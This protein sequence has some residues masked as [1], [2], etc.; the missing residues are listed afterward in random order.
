[1]KK[2]GLW[3]DHR[4]TVLVSMDGDPAAVR[5]RTIESG[6]ESRPRMG[7]G[8]GPAT[9]Y[10]AQDASYEARRDRRHD[11]QLDQYYDRVIEAVSGANQ[12]LVMGPGEARTEFAK[13]LRSSGTIA[14]SR[15]TVIAADRMTE[16]QILEAVKQHFEIPTREV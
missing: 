11:H 10:G 3:I 8:A 6:V 12:V 1:M 4:K 15:V 14:R 5:A 9:P 16:P 13:R 7:G 2:V